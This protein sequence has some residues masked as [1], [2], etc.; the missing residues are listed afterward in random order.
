M[1]KRSGFQLAG[2]LSDQT[3][4]D[5]PV[6]PAALCRIGAGGKKKSERCE[7]KE[8]N[9]IGGERD[10]MS[11][12]EG[13]KIGDEGECAAPNWRVKPANKNRT[14]QRG[15]KKQEMIDESREKVM[16][17]ASV[18]SIVLGNLRELLITGQLLGWARQ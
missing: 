1:T 3:A 13:D 10:V 15:R 9:D 17:I 6:R 5:K 4:F 11:D 16:K 7:E 18:E 8:V 12:G 14:T 2:S